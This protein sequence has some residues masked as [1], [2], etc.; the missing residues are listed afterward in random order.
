M[1]KT[2]SV[3]RVM[4]KRKALKIP[5][6]NLLVG[7]A[8][9]WIL[10]KLL[11][12]KETLHFY[13]KRASQIGI[14]AYRTSSARH[15]YVCV[16]NFSQEENALE[17]YLYCTFEKIYMEKVNDG[18]SV[19]I[20]VPFDKVEVDIRLHLSFCDAKKAQSYSRTL[21][22]IYEENKEIEIAC[23]YPEAEI[24]EIFLDAYD[25]MDLF[26]D[27]EA[28]EVLYNYATTRNMNGKYLNIY[29]E[30]SLKEKGYNFTKADAEQFLNA[31]Q[32]KVMHTRFKGYLRNQKRKEPDYDTVFQILR[33]LFEPIVQ[34]MTE[35][36]IF[37]GDWMAE[38]GRYL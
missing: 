1:E 33:S 9:E 2:L 34:A 32:G 13:L 21:P 23:F 19:L 5:Y 35:Q 11:S 10:E 27:M 18:L 30:E 7:Y 12:E 16:V 26:T 17:Q 36:R 38:L 15:L 31:M 4:E 3:S 28:L 24:V 22:L 37:F 20:K 25:K 14:D 6:Q 29:L 8:K